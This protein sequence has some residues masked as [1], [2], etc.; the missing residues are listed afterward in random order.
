MK[1]NNNQYNKFI[2]SLQQTKTK[3]ASTNKEAKTNGPSR[4]SVEINFS[5]EAKKLSE[6]SEKET[7]SQRVEDI[8]SA[9]QNN[10]YEVDTVGITKGIVEA[11]KHQKGIE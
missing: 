10:T 7:H 8:K 2:Q 6:I 4:K 9:I 11:I 1:I 5:D 3:A